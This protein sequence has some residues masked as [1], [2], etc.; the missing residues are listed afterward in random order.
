MGLGGN[1]L[2]YH[3]LFPIVLRFV[4][5][6][7]DGIVTNGQEIKRWV[8]H[9]E[10]V[11]P[12]KIQVIP[13][14]T[15]PPS[16]PDRVPE[17]FERHPASV[18]IGIVANLTPIKRIDVFLRALQLLAEQRPDIPFQALV[19]G[20]G[21]EREA[22]FALASERKIAERVH[23]PGAVRDV[24]PFLHRFDI[25]VL[26]SDREGFSNSVLEYMAHSLPVV[27]TAVGGNIDLVD[28]SIG[29]CVPPGDSNALAESLIRLADDPSL[30]AQLGK[31]GREKVKTLYS[32]ERSMAEL[33]GYYLRLLAAKA[34]IG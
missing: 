28:P 10:W 19:L 17:L 8:S 4:S 15:A 32:W 27:V 33:E 34:A 13:N 21:P 16:L 29:F 12:E 20:E 31:A 30:R 3:R 5:R 9:R 23:F 22:L 18:W 1:R 7:F 26:C 11:P 25:G 6:H 2:W 14:G 24:S